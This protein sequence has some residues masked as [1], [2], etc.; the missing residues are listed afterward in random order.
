MYTIAGSDIVGFADADWAGAESDGKSYTGF[1][2]KYAGAALLWKNKKQPTVALSSTE[3]EYIGLA[4]AC[5][6]AIYLQIGKQK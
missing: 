3:A 4:E 6:E 1:V 2:F 5:K